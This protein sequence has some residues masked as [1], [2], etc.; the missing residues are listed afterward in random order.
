MEI[1]GGSALIVMII[2][3]LGILCISRSASKSVGDSCRMLNDIRILHYFDRPEI[4]KALSKNILP[5]I[6]Q[7]LCPDL[8]Q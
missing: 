8:K 3:T 7:N 5:L 2:A 1:F 4:G 6:V